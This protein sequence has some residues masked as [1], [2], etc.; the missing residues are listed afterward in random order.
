MKIW[1]QR[2]NVSILK[3]N[4][5]NTYGAQ[6]KD[7]QKKIKIFINKDLV[8]E[9]IFYRNLTNGRSLVDPILR[10]EEIAI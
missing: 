8:K 9:W 6:R 1:G 10:I 3:D 2:F 5:L 7:V 4:E